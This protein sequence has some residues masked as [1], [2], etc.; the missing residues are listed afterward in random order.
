MN[1]VTIG[2]YLAVSL[3]L[4]TAALAAWAF[5]PTELPEVPA[6]APA[7]VAEA[8]PPK[9]PEVVELA[10]VYVEA[11]APRKA[12]PARGKKKVC[13]VRGNTHSAGYAIP[14]TTVVKGETLAKVCWFE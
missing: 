9:A 13:D 7:V 5:Q 1:H 11:E 10:P 12:A 14:T 8:A 6:D 3:S 2:S 4:A